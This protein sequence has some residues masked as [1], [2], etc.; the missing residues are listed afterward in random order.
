MASE[1]YCLASIGEALDTVEA[2]FSSVRNAR[3]V[4]WERVGGRGS[5]L[6]EAGGWGKN[7]GGSRGKT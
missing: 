3:V 6:I 5:T 7:R 1:W 2:W 4:R